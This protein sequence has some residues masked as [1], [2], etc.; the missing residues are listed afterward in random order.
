LGEFSEPQPDL[1]L[2]KRRAEGKRIVIY[3]AP[4]ANGYLRKGEFA[5][6]AT[7]AP[8]AFPDVKITVGDLFG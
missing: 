2:L 7:V 1:M 5:G 4:A 8:H 6:A 3:R